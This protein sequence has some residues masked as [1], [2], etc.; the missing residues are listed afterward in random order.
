MRLPLFSTSHTQLQIQ[1]P[2]AVFIDGQAVLC[3]KGI[4]MR[5]DGSFCDHR[6]LQFAHVSSATLCDQRISAVYLSAESVS[7]LRVIPNHWTK[8]WTEHW[9]NLFTWI[10]AK[11]LFQWP[12]RLQRS[13]PDEVLPPLLMRSH[14]TMQGDAVPPKARDPWRYSKTTEQNRDLLHFVTY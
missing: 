12:S 10:V 11:V 13:A 1:M 6:C 3:A 2:R 8:H 5:N 9:T 7:I 14:L 4:K